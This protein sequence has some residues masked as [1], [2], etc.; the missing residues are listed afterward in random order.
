MAVVQLVPWRV[1]LDHMGMRMMDT[2]SRLQHTE[3][4][5]STI[6]F[7][8]WPVCGVDSY[9]C[10]LPIGIFRQLLKSKVYATKLDLSDVVGR[11]KSV[12]QFCKRVL[13]MC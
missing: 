13:D 2:S 1:A 8:W 6:R 9:L 10:C 5:N 3:V 7:G 11:D 12:D 4:K